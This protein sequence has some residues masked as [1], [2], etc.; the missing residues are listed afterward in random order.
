MSP[1]INETRTETS[2]AIA[3][4]TKQLATATGLASLWQ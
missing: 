3:T 2:G 4:V 1:D